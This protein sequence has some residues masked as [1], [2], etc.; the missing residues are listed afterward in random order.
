MAEV[1]GCGD[2]CRFGC[3][4]F[5]S[6]P[7]SWLFTRRVGILANQASVTREFRNVVD[8]VVALGGR[9]TA[10]FSP[11]HGFFSEKQANM[12]ESDHGIHP[13]YGIPVFSLYGEVRRPTPD[14]LERID[15][16][17]IDL[18][19][20]GTRV[21]TYG[22]TVGL[23]VEAAAAAGVDVV[24]L[25]RPNPLGGAR[26]EG[27]LVQEEYRS[28]VGR[29]ALP[30]RHGLTLGELALWVSRLLGRPEAVQ[31]VP[32]QGWR[33][34]ALWPSTGR[35]WI[36]PSPN[37]PSWETALVYPGMVLLEGTNVSEGRGTTLPFMLFGAPFV[38]PDELEA[39]LDP[40]DRQGVVLRPVSF[41]PTFD[42]WAGRLCRGFHLVVTDP[43]RFWPYRFGLSLLRAFL[44][45]YPDQFQWL[46]PPYEYDH[47]H[48]PM[49]ILIGDG[50]IRKALEEGE[51]LDHLEARWLS[52]LKE[53]EASCKP[54]LVY[55]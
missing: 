7:P 21:Y 18:Q 23:C 36:F 46:P 15:V 31:V 38:E 13:R 37:M 45:A 47:E 9:V 28:F 55:S 49:D 4:V 48:L 5:L 3:D 16:F 30:M 29:Y 39:H 40:R 24:V 42:K 41:E 17:L 8:A 51:S 27:N 54:A 1:S 52:D 53:F 25:D 35:P 12:I 20:V 11:Q 6:E 50:Q 2:S 32:V 22:T 19:D 14:M 26:L 44:R 33:R 43:D 34:D 10:V